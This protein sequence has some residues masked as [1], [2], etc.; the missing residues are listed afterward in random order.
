MPVVTRLDIGSESFELREKPSS[1]R[2]RYAVIGAYRAFDATNAVKDP[3]NLG[4][5]GTPHPDDP[6][7][8]LLSS[9]Y[10]ATERLGAGGDRGWYVDVQFTPF[11][12]GANF[13]E[14]PITEPTYATAEFSTVDRIIKAPYF[15]KSPLSFESGGSLVDSFDWK[16]GV[17]EF[18]V[19]GL[20]FRAVV[21]VATTA[22]YNL[23]AFIATRDQSNVIHTFGLQNWLYQGAVSSQVSID[24]WQVTHTW[25]A[26]PGNDAPPKTGDVPN[27]SDI[28]SAPDRGAFEDYQKFTT[29]VMGPVIGPTYTPGIGVRTVYETNANGYTG[30]VGDPIGRVLAL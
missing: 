23:G 10:V 29:P 7:G 22:S 26:D 4:P 6:S 2:I 11:A 28:I 30:L 18:T 15:F 14:P 21:N 24:V 20:Q 17:Q 27:A 25:Y 19:T 12:G 8:N 13:E 9:S 16:E 5:A 1:A 3:L